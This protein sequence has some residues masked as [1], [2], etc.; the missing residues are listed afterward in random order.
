MVIV[1]DGAE[2]SDVDAVL[3]IVPTP[4]AGACPFIE[5]KVGVPVE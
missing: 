4:A 3:K 2:G 1:V 5:L